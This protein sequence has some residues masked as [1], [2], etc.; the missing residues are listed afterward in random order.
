M[1]RSLFF[2]LSRALLSDSVALV[3]LS[4][5]LRRAGYASLS[6]TRLP[7]PARLVGVSPSHD[8][9]LVSLAFSSLLLL[10]ITQHTLN[11][12][13]PHED[14]AKNHADI[15]MLSITFCCASTLASRCAT[16][17][18]IFWYSSFVRKTPPATD[19]AARALPL[20]A[21]AA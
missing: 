12:R 21:T 3:T 9:W 18:R 6:D 13:Q 5:H 11:T 16:Q 7:R 10:H 14:T 4:L 20:S 15:S 19:A 1:Q 17:L 8:S 2:C